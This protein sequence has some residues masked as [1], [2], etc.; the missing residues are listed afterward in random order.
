[1]LSDAAYGRS[2]KAWLA[3]ADASAAGPA[4]VH[5]HL[6]LLY[7]AS[8]DTFAAAAFHAKCDGQGP[9]LTIVTRAQG[10]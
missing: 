3:E 5:E 8:R 2:L 9:T 4:P 7:R 1:M 10:P 6:A